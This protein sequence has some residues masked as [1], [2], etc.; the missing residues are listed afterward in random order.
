M[1]DEFH[2]GVDAFSPEGAPVAQLI[3]SM[4]IYD[5]LMALLTDADPKAAAALHQLHSEGKL[6]GS[7]PVLRVEQ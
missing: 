1:N 6:L 5:V 3:V 2:E 4:R 7:W